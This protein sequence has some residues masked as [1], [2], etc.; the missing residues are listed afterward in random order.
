[1]S[2]NDDHENRGLVP[3]YYVAGDLV[4]YVGYEYVPELDKRKVG[5][6]VGVD[7]LNSH[8]THYKVFWLRDNITSAH[9]GNHLQLVYN[10]NT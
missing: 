7:K 1:M 5:I 8:F 4:Y 9:V 3:E 10:K 2:K 6:V